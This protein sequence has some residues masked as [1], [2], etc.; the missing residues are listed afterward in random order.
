MLVEIIQAKLE[1]GTVNIVGCDQEHRQEVYEN[2][3][4]YDDDSDLKSCCFFAFHDNEKERKQLFRFLSSQ[5]STRYIPK[6][7]DALSSLV[8]TVVDVP[9]NRRIAYYDGMYDNT[10]GR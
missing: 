7:E 1:D 5:K 6:L 3:E 2:R 8:G 10:L 9:D 4:R